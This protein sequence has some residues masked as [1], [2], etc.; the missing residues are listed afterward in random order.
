MNSQTNGRA[1]DS[2]GPTWYFLPKFITVQAPKRGVAHYEERLKG[3]VVG[4]FNRSQQESG[5]GVCSNGS[6]HNWL[7]AHRP[8]VAFC[9]HQ[10]D[11]CDTC[12]RLKTE[13]QVKQTTNN[14]LLQSSNALP[15]EVKKVQDEKTALQ[16]TLENH[17]QEAQRSHT[18]YTEVLARCAREWNEIAELEKSTLSSEEDQ[19]A[20]LKNKFILVIC[21][22]YQMFKLV[23]YWGMSAQPG[24]TYYFRSLTMTLLA[25]WT[26]PVTH[27]Q[28]ICLMSESA[29]RIQITRYR[30]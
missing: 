4:E 10:E 20:S 22:D 30:I 5:K 19:L 6:S 14:C 24:S 3:S 11:Y 2:L 27:Q 15:E 7:K 29:L 26:I 21:A 23:P 28:F 25:S 18:Y 16:Q 8:K 1:A 17:R 13:I 9:P 12:A